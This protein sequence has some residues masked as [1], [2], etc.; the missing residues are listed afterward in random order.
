MFSESITYRNLQFYLPFIP[1][2]L[3]DSTENKFKY[4]L[5]KLLKKDLLNEFLLL[6]HVKKGRKTR[7]RIRP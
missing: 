4:A 1:K 6:L 3:K 7:E 5:K 2:N